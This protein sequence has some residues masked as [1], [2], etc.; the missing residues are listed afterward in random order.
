MDDHPRVF[1]PPL[2][3]FGVLVGAGLVWDAQLSAFGLPQAIALPLGLLGL[4]LIGAALDL[5]RRGRTRPE[6]WQ[7]AS[8]LVV[9]G[10]YRWTRNPM[11]LGM[12]VSA[13]ATALFLESVPGAVLGVTAAMLID[14]FVI[15]REEAYLS[16]RFGTEFRSYVE[17]VRRWF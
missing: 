12:A 1:V 16:R 2:L 9:L 15:P 6:P 5:F 7:P 14:H 3:I 10:V 17:Q 4:A 8:A 13:L 11:Y